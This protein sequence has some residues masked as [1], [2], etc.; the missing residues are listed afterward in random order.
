[1]NRICTLGGNI[2]T[3]RDEF[4]ELINLRTACSISYVHLPN[5]KLPAT[6]YLQWF[7]SKISHCD[8]A[9]LNLDYLDEITKFEIAIINTINAISDKYVFI[10]G[11]GEEI[12]LPQYIKEALFHI[13]YSIEDV[14]DYIATNLII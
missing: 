6:E 11:Y 8:V 2:T 7:I 13:S 14:A 9:I 1:M 3:W 10:V 4:E 5:Y 12:N